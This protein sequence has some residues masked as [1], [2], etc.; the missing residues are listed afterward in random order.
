MVAALAIL[1]LALLAAPAARAATQGVGAAGVPDVS[2]A[3]GTTAVARTDGTV[4]TWGANDLGQQGDGTTTPSEVPGQ[5][6]VAAATPLTDVIALAQGCTTGYALRVDG[7]VWSWGGNQYGELGIGSSSGPST[8]GATPCS[9]YAV[10]VRTSNA[11]AYLGSVKS[12]AAGT[13]FALAVR[14]DGTVWA[15]GRG[16]SGQ[17]GNQSTSGPNTCNA[18]GCSQLAIRAT[19]PGAASGYLQSVTDIAAGAA[20]SA[21][22][23][24]DGSVVAWGSD[25]SG[26][27]GHGSTS[28]T[29]LVP[30][31]V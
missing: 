10:Q 11:P 4:W 13:S 22:L 31:A 2:A 17:L 23:R 9:P 27:T 15:W 18:V 26:A 28:G 19:D 14:S 25:A 8:C 12:I 20:S 6:L 7:S 1:L 29:T 16:D 3:C 30:T 5:V 24:V 21:A